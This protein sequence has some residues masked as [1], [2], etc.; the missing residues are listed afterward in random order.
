VLLEQMTMTWVDPDPGD[1]IQ[2]VR[3]E[4]LRA[5]GLYENATLIE[6]EVDEQWRQGEWVFE[7]STSKRLVV[8]RAAANALVV[9]TYE[10]AAADWSLVVNSFRDSGKRISILMP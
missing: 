1:R 6:A 7:S 4:A 3:D 2:L 9:V 10:V 5:H 8:I